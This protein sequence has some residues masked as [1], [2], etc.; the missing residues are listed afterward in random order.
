MSDQV[1][2]RAKKVESC[3]D[4]PEMRSCEKVG[5][6]IGN[7]KIFPAKER[8]KSVFDP[9][10]KWQLVEEYGVDSFTEIAKRYEGGLIL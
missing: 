1:M 5:A 6:I 9:S 10:M 8:V 7:K 3:G 2:R 4:C